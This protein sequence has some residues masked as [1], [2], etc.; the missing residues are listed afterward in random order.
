MSRH[1]PTT[2]VANHHAH[3]INIHLHREPC[4][5]RILDDIGGAFGMGAVGGGIW[6][7]CK[8]LYNSPKGSRM[9]GGVDVRD[10]GGSSDHIHIIH[11]NLTTPQAIRR[12]APRIGGGFAVW[13]GLFSMFDCTLVAVRRKEDPWNSIAAGALT[14]GVLQLRTGLQSAARSAAFGGV[15]LV[16]D[17]VLSHMQ[18][19][20][21]STTTTNHYILQAMIEGLGILLTRATTPPPAPPPVMEMPTAGVSPGQFGSTS[22][23]IP[24][25]TPSL[26]A[27]PSPPSGDA[28][29][30]SGGGWLSGWFGGGSSGG[31]D[32]KQ[33]GTKETD[34]TED[35]F[36]PP[37][38][39]T[40]NTELR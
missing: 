17:V 6:H 12:E 27:A 20:K 22:S 8:G 16:R 7:L 18:P 26:D 13:G 25:T 35:K 11:T 2:L 37:Q 33:G 36:A 39:P 15:L 28:G 10:G 1:L 4:P 9:R 32:G 30:S 31:E 23:P 29:G 38:M 21:K 5:D 3:C 24:G 14:G 34:L 40:F 19:T